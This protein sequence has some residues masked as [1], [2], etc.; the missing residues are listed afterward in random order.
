MT[1]ASGFLPQN[2]LERNLAISTFI[3]TFGNGLFLVISVLYFT[4]IMGFSAQQIGIALTI[5]GQAELIVTIPSGHVADR[6]SPRTIAITTAV[7]FAVWE[8]SFFV[9]TSYAAFVAILVIQGI[10]DGFSRTS[11]QAIYA[12]AAKPEDRVRLRAYLRSMTNVGIGLGSAVGAIAI[13]VDERWMYFVVIGIDIATYLV[14]ALI[15][16]RIPNIDSHPQAREHHWSLAMRDRP[17]VMLTI[18]NAVFATHFILLDTVI[19]LWIIHDVQAP[20]AMIAITFVINTAMAATLQV[21]MSKG[22]ED[23]VVAANFNCPG[24]VV[25]SGSIKGVEIGDGFTTA[26]RRGSVAHD[27]IEKDSQGKIVRRTDRAGGT[28]GG[29]SNGEVLRVSIAMKPISTVPKALDTIDVVTGEPAKA[30][31]QRSDVC[32]VP[33]AG[34]VGEAMAALVLAEAVLEKFGGDSVS[35]TRRNYLSYMENLRFK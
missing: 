17:F 27:E 30:I 19:P 21:R 13:A 5:G 2:S 15:L 32:A 34:V 12:R 20:K 3:N 22:T 31:N 14:S 7:L 33:A 1:K 24:Q 28:E 16:T 23:V 26:T 29:M 11:R 9:I 8:T 18:L 35:E 10:L 6:I 25:I 4:R